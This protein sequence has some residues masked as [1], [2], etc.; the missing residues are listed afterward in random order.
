[1]LLAVLLMVA[2]VVDGAAGFVVQPNN[3]AITWSGRS[4]VNADGS[5]TSD[6][7]AQTILLSIT[8]T[9][10]ISLLMNESKTNRYAVYNYS[11]AEGA[12]Q[13]FRD[14]AIGVREVDGRDHLVPD[15]VAP[16]YLVVPRVEVLRPAYM[17][18]DDLVHMWCH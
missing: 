14:A 17:F 10:N 18:A 9:T 8:G 2:V 11:T 16:R 15:L 5:R 1:M 7:A 12:T 6:W 3:P 13:V 4:I